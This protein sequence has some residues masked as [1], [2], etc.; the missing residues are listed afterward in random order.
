MA[1]K[2]GILAGAG[3]LPFKLVEVC[4]SQGRDVFV[5]AFE[6]QTDPRTME[7]V[8][9]AWIRLGAA[10]SGMKLL[11]DAGVGEVVMAGAVERPSLT[12]LRPDL[13]TT[14]WLARMGAAALGDDGLLSGIIRTLEAEGFTVLGVDELLKDLVAKAGTYGKVNP[15][16]QS[17]R[18]IERGV[19]VARRLGEQDVGQAVVVQQGLV[20]AVEAI[21][22]TDAL[23]ARA[24]EL[25]R[26]GPGGVLVKVKK[27]QQEERADLPSI[28]PRTVAGAQAAGLSG[29][30]IE[31]GGGLVIDRARV[32]EAADAAGLFLIGLTLDP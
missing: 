5:L 13:S 25:R 28:G 27:P 15:D 2:L 4:R 19:A 24:G 22:G 17:R 23:L 7:G 32:V 21:E 6:G 9:H 10:A 16:E 11:T 29:I 30:A 26:E 14:R 31:A 18:D 20:L 12:E 8:E 3:A 1:G